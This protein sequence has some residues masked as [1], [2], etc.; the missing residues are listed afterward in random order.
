MDRA[1]V[2]RLLDAAAAGR[3]VPA[4][5]RDPATPALAELGEILR[6]FGQFHS[7]DRPLPKCGNAS[8]GSLYA[9]QLYVEA[10]GNAVAGLAPGHHYYHP[11]H[12]RLVLMSGAD[13]TAG[14]SG[15]LQLTLTFLMGK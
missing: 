10:D 3:P 4:P 7:P 5:R 1:D 9:T 15:G 12:H 6:Y 13:R 8:P 11:V 2:P 14:P